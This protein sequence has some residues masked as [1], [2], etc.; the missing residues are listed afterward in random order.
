[1]IM[2]FLEKMYTQKELN[3]LKE[4]DYSGML[5]DLDLF[6]IKSQVFHYLKSNHQLG[7]QSSFLLRHTKYSYENSSYQNLML[8]HELGQLL[9][10]F[11]SETLSVIPLKGIIFS[12]T[13][14]GNFAA[15]GTADIDLF[16]RPSDLQEA[17]VLVKSA[18]FT[19]EETED[20][21]NNHITFTKE[22][23]NSSLSVSVELHWSLDK[24]Y[25]SDLNPEFFWENSMSYS[26]YKN[27][28]ILSLQDT[29]YFTCI[30]ATR[31]KMDSLKYFVDLLQILVHHSSE[32]GF[33]ELK[34]RATIDKTWKKVN[35]CLSILYREL[36]FLEEI[37]PYPFKMPIVIWSLDNARKA[38]K[39]EKDLSYYLYKFYFNHCLF[40]SPKHLFTSMKLFHVIFPPKTNLKFFLGEGQDENSRWSLLKQYYR[41]LIQQNRFISY[42]A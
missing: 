26:N 25:Y 10:L 21:S 14:F 8:R 16:I 11:E 9:D 27:V 15:R 40:D 30:H 23:S 7:S 3:E 24:E 36:P 35:A 32:I 4:V 12:E 34:R 41:T 38:Q 18:G 13:Y 6:S 42:K 29:F 37:K 2:S 5:N 33:Y 28:R 39:N 19:K 20:L 22:N 1:M 31:H 17:I